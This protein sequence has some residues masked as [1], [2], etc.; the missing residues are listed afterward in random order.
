KAEREDFPL[1]V[2]AH[3]AHVHLDGAG[4][5]GIRGVAQLD[6]EKGDVVAGGGAANLDFRS[7][8]GGIAAHDRAAGGIDSYGGCAG[9]VEEHEAFHEGDARGGGHTAE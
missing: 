9:L 1:A 4:V 6:W 8:C 5:G 2:F 7:T 3:E